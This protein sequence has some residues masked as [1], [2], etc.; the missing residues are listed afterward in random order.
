MSHVVAATGNMLTTSG[1]NDSHRIKRQN[2]YLYS[3][4]YLQSNGDGKRVFLID[5]AVILSR[6]VTGRNLIF[7]FLLVVVGTTTVS[8]VILPQAAVP[9]VS[10]S[11][12]PASDIGKRITHHQVHHDARLIILLNNKQLILTRISFWY[13]LEQW[14]FYH[15]WILYRYSLALNLFTLYGVTHFLFVLVSRWLRLLDIGFLKATPIC[16]NA[17]APHDP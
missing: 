15:Q 13:S 8:V 16:M 4:L 1:V 10:R 2:I 12:A 9:T 17:A 6:D 7:Y 3:I 5:N 14:I 11:I